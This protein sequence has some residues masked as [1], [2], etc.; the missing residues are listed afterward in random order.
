[1]NYSNPISSFILDGIEWELRYCDSTQSQQQIVRARFLNF[2]SR[3]RSDAQMRIFYENV[4]EMTVSPTRGY[5]VICD[6]LRYF[7]IFVY[8]VGIICIFSV[9]PPRTECLRASDLIPLLR[10]KLVILSGK[11]II[12]LQPIK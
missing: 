7:A 1:M 12:Q 3:S 10:Q 5:Y 9:A 8:K 2:G 6:I 4:F 11:T